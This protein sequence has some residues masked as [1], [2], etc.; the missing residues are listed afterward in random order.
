VIF[1]EPFCDSLP[2]SIPLKIFRHCCICY[3]FILLWAVMTLV[4]HDFYVSQM[5]LWLYGCNNN[6]FCV[7]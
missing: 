2:L 7:A 5:M 1:S 3:S 4:A 6:V